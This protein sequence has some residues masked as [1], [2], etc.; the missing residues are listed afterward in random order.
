MKYKF[1]ERRFSAHCISNF[2]DFHSSVSV[3]G[4]N[5]ILHKNQIFDLIPFVKLYNVYNALCKTEIQG[6]YLTAATYFYLKVS[7]NHSCQ[8]NVAE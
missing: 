5:S 7:S 6:L 4:L 2:G 1:E 3:D 8:V